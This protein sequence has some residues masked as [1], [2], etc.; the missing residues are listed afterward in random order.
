M[1]P[2]HTWGRQKKYII[3]F[4]DRVHVRIEAMKTTAKYRTD[5][6]SYNIQQNTFTTWTDINTI[7]LTQIL[8]HIIE[9]HL[10][11]LYFFLSPES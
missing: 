10:Q 11:F 7:N 9:L 3:F 2:K 8:E 5:Y 6:I 4:R 1:V